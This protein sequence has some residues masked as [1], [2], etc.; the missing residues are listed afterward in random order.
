MT[1]LLDWR[2]GQAAFG[3]AIV[4]ALVSLGGCGGNEDLAAPLPSDQATVEESLVQITRATPSPVT[5]EQ[6]AE[7]F[8]LMS[9]S[10]DVQR[11]MLEKDVV[12]SVVEWDIQVY[13]VE[14]ADGVY[15]VTSKAI[16][17]KSGDANHG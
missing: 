17:I 1:H 9:S 14:F 16:P 10:T 2:F 7:A 11:E 3:I 8:A 6:L 15:T 4:W 12:G 5:P 13:E